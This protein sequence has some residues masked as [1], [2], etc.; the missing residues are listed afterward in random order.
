MSVKWEMSEDEAQTLLDAVSFT[1]KNADGDLARRARRV[2]RHFTLKDPIT[3][4]EP[5]QE[6]AS[7]FLAAFGEPV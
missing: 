3:G 2:V 1:A 6:N 7:E 4:E 5:T